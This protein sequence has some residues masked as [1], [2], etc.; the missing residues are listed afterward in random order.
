MSLGRCLVGAAILGMGAAV[1]CSESSGNTGPGQGGD[2]AVA[3][4][5]GEA[6]Q[7]Q[8]GADAGS[9]AGRGG[10]SSGSGGAGAVAGTEAGGSP[11]GGSAGAPFTGP[12][13]AVMGQL[14]AV[15]ETIAVVELN[16]FPMPYVSATLWDRKNPWLSEAELSTETCGY[17]HYEPGVCGD[18]CDMGEVCSLDSHCVPERRTVKDATLTLEADNETREYSSD[19]EFGYLSS[20]VDIGDASSSYAMTLSWGDIVVELAPMKVG[21]DELAGAKVEIAGDSQKPGALDAS[22]TSAD[23]GAFVRST[24]PINHHAGGPTFTEC[25]APVSAGAFHADAAMVDPLAVITGLEFQG[26]EQV[27]I[28][29]AETPAGCVEFRFGARLSV[30]PD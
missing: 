16:G 19:P 8:G 26:L 14:C 1:G 4:G 21:S 29:A 17:H 22:W 3:G 25:A 6:G 28:A 2:P 27:Y 9:G 20:M 13:Q 5:S 11:E 23:T 18:A 7:Q 15:E 24:I 30:F 10:A 12:F